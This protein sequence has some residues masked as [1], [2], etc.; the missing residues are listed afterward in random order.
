M[1]WKVIETPL[2]L[3]GQY[4]IV[5]APTKEEA[6]KIVREMYWDQSRTDSIKLRASPFKDNDWR[7]GCSKYD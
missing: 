1:T 7:V 6:K 3:H 4:W 5:E 2:W